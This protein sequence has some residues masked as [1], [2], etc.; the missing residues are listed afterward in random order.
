MANAFVLFSLLTMFHV[1]DV[2]ADPPALTDV[3]RIH[4]EP[5]NPWSHLDFHNDEA[6]FQF[7][8][9]TDRTG[10]H[11]GTVFE[12][13]L[14][15]VNLLEPEFVMSVGDLIEGY[16]H[17][18]VAIASQ[19]DE[20]ETFVDRLD[21]PF[22]YLPGNHDIQNQVMAQVWKE[23]F[24]PSYY[25]FVYRDVLFLCLNTEDGKRGNISEAQIEYA[26][27]ALAENEDVRWTLVFLHQPLWVYTD[28]DGELRDT[29]WAGIE[30]LIR[31]RQHTVFAGH[32]HSYFK[33]VRNE[34]N[35]FI[36]ATA[37]GVSGMRGPLYGEFD[38]AVWVTM[39]DDGPKVTNLMLDGIWDEDI[40]TEEIVA[41]T[42]PLL[43]GDAIAIPPLFLEAGNELTAAAMTLRLKND[44]DVPVAIS[45]HFA[46]HPTVAVSPESLELVMPPNSMEIVDLSASAASGGA[47]REH[48][49]V[50]FDW[51]AT[52]E[53]EE[54]AL[55]EIAGTVPLMVISLSPSVGIS[56]TGSS[57]VVDGKLSDWADLPVVVKVAPDIR[58]SDLWEGP[59]D[60]SWRFGVTRDDQFIYVG[61]EVL[62]DNLEPQKRK[63]VPVGAGWR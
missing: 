56:H 1:I 32:F 48:E 13:G 58:S 35:Y 49:A 46:S 62:D 52:Y 11:R 4:I 24:G 25:H 18:P 5:V 44:A 38:H 14:S 2:T 7:A 17:D 15:K 30:A 47:L 55:P 43:S 3:A 27:R 26:Q 63:E 42:R 33:Y 54:V 50:N 59:D 23:R 41:Y 10:G 37:G 61:I 29:G 16:S 28:D 20:F 51:S 12:D 60:C 6:N 53:Q 8:I 21:M 34:Q 9:V 19:W 36:L 45:G 31:D 57:I 39:M 40:R 22:F